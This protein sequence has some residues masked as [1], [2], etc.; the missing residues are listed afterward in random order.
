M[1]KPYVIYI[2]INIFTFA[3]FGLDKR[4]GLK[5]RCRISEKTLLTLCLL[6]GAAG[7][8]AGMKFFHHKS[9][10][11]YF[12]FTVPVMMVLQLAAMVY[13]TYF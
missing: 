13:F 1:I 12:A 10:K 2:F 4:K 11:W 9:A 5:G 6:M 3:A 8:W 7:G